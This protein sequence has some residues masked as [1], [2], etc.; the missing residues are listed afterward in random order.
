M[1]QPLLLR[2]I[3]QIA[4]ILALLSGGAVALLAFLVA[5]DIISR[6]FMG[7]SL[8]GT[9]ELGGYVLAIV[10]ALG[11]GFTLLRRGHPRIDIAF[12]LFPPRLRDALHILAYASLTAMA[13]FM[14]YHSLEEFR[15]TLKFGTVTN[16]PQI[17]RAHV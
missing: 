8:Q 13:V 16:T 4:R 14:A 7:F 15:Q 1:Q 3:E 2:G 11:F 9:D 6:R 5:F 12:G 17:G 10:G